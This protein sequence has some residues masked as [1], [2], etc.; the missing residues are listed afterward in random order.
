[1]D[2]QSLIIPSDDIFTTSA[3]LTIMLILFTH[4]K[5]LLNEL[6]NLL[7][8]S[9]GNLD[10]HIRKLIESNYVTTRKAI[11]PRRALTVVEITAIGFAD[12]KK[13]LIKMKNVLD[14]I[15]ID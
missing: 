8:L 2:K 5:V 12:F 4:K 7:H 10:H 1:M 11:F 6:K 9:S 13:Y 15:S 14:Q 3:R